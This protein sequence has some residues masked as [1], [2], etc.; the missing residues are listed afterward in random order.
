MVRETKLD[1]MK[2]FRKQGLIP[3]QVGF[4]VS[5]SWLLNISTA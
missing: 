1:E 4:G 2:S 5:I 3:S